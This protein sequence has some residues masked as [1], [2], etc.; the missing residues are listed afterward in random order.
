ME[1]ERWQ[2]VK[3]LFDAALTRA[4]SERRVFLE[5]ACAGDPA[6]ADEVL[7]LL[8]SFAHAE[9]VVEPAPANASDTPTEEPRAVALLCNRK[10]W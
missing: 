7:S 1:P 5:R 6:L 4:S 8:E 2:R 9:S 10:H 3:D